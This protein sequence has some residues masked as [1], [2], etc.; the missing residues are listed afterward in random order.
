MLKYIN[1][2]D[3]NSIKIEKYIQILENRR[4]KPDNIQLVHVL[5]V[6]YRMTTFYYGSLVSLYKVFFLY[7]FHTVTKSRLNNILIPPVR[8]CTFDA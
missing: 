4:S 7:E 2:C 8:K 3:K 1:I 6:L 5:Y